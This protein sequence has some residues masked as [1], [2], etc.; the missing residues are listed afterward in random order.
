MM[1]PHLR[2]FLEENYAVPADDLPEVKRNLYLELL[3]LPTVAVDFTTPEGA[4]LCLEEAYRRKDIEAAVRAKN[5]ITEARLVLRK[6]KLDI[7]VD[8]EESVAKTAELLEMSFRSHTMT[9]WPDFSSQ[10]SF[11]PKIEVIDDR[12]VAVTEVCRFQD[13]LF[14]KQ[15]ILVGRTAEG[16][17]VLNPA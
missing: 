6:S 17:R 14:S 10:E 7:L 3:A 11:F 13:G 1:T 2:L 4:I 15:Q 16:W 5:F 9:E 8:D 12:I